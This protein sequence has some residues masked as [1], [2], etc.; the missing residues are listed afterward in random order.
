MEIGHVLAIVVTGLV[1]VFIGLTVLILLV[2][3]LGKILGNVKK[4]T[5]P[6]PAAVAKIA[7]AVPIIVSPT[8]EDG[9]SDE[10]VA[11]IMAAIASISC[12]ED[13]K[14]YTVR[15][16]KTARSTSGGR[17]IWGLAGLQDNTR[18]F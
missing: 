6:I 1:I 5:P 12:E 14:T 16:I 11:V 15:G 10:V 8:I 3:L 7:P 17:P 2:S 18:A 9:I 13:G 4:T